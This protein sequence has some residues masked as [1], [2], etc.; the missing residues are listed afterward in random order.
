[1]LDSWRWVSYRRKLLVVSGTLTSHFLTLC[2]KSKELSKEVFKTSTWPTDFLSLFFALI[3]LEV[4]HINK[5]YILLNFSFWLLM[6]FIFLNPTTI[7][8]QLF[9]KQ[10]DSLKTNLFL[11]N[12]NIQLCNYNSLWELYWRVNLLTYLLTI[13]NG[14]EK[15]F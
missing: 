12:N 4:L 6:D 14:V 1:M 13:R 9:K 15:L 7:L 8:K 2:P 3:W 5:S 10:D 11:N